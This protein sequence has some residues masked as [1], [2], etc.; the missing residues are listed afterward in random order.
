MEEETEEQMY[1]SGETASS[2]QP[3]EKLAQRVS[4]WARI[5]FTLSEEDKHAAGIRD[6]KKDIF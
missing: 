5:F 3:I 1:G 6:Y 4:E 2:A